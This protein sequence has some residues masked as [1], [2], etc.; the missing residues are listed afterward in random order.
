MREILPGVWHWSAFHE[1][2]RTHVSSYYVEAAEALLDP[3]LPQEGIEWFSRR[4]RPPRRILLTNR[5]HYRHSDRFGAELGCDVRCSRPG[6]HEFEGT[7]RAVEGFDFGAEVAPGVV[8]VEVGEICPDE[9]AL[10]MAGVGAV[11]VADAVIRDGDG[12]LSFVPDQYMGDDHEA[13][14]AGLR[15][16]LGRLA[17][18]DFE[19]LL[20]AHG[21]PLL[22]DGRSALRDFVSA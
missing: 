16:S 21:P 1:G 13:V 7:D 10:E 15:E 2:I 8:A 20:L 11:A 18:R 9:T 5:H 6:L 14:K 22:G 19:H 12:P 17:E 4:E 3:M